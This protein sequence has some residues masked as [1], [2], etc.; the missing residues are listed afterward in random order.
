LGG[1]DRRISEFEASLVYKKKKK[2][3][4][5]KRPRGH[6]IYVRVWRKE[7]GGRYDVIIVA[8]YKKYFSK[9][10]TTNINDCLC[11]QKQSISQA[12]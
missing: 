3:K 4:K 7:W 5:K 11:S 8:K 1:R 2:K 9:T 12:V 6:G 10:C